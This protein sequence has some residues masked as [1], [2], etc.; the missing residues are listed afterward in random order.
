MR[1]VKERARHDRA[2]KKHLNR[3]NKRF[4]GNEP[5]NVRP[6]KNTM[7]VERKAARD[8]VMVTEKG[9]QAE[10]RQWFGTGQT[11]QLGA[12]DLADE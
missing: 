8:R 3:I 7:V 4:C 1:Q 10:G 2:G 11:A 5:I 9:E 12:I 6:M